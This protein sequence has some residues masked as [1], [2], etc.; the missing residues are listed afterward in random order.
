MPKFASAGVPTDNPTMK[1]EEYVNGETYCC[2]SNVLSYTLQFLKIK[3]LV[4]YFTLILEIFVSGGGGGQE[5]PKE[6]RKGGRDQ[7]YSL[8]IFSEYLKGI[9]MSSEQDYPNSI[10]DKEKSSRAVKSFNYS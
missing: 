3:K 10:S 8:N 1:I 9:K 7:V 2:L 5:L 4:Q 6:M